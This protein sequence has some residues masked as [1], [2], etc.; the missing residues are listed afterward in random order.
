MIRATHSLAL[1]AL[2]IAAPLAA[3]DKEKLCNDLQSRPMRVG[4]WASYNWTGG[5]TGGSAMRMAIVGTEPIDGTPYYW[6]EIS[7]MDAAKGSKARTIVQVLIPG[8]GSLATNV[9]GMIM[10]SGDDPA[11][12]MPDQMVQM[13]RGQMGQNFA[14]EFARNCLEM[15]T[16]GWEQITVPGGSFRVLHLR[17][18]AE[19]TDAWL[20][21]DFY[22]GLVR[23][24]VKD[25]STMELTARGTDAKSSITEKPVAM[26]GMPR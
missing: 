19:Q 24:K 20:A 9:R 21:P 7:F 3:Q 12:R 15:D 26:P 18:A 1:Y 6:Y 17:H 23:A 8:L 5:R 16:V 10:K 2:L 14:T 25:G 13:V 4:Q 22:F 11:M